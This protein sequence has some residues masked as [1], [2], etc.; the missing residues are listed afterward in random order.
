MAGLH[1]DG[2]AFGQQCGQHDGV[3]VGALDL[4][5][6]GLEVHVAL[7]ERFG[8]R[9]RNL[10]VFQGLLEVVVAALGEDV[11]VAV[12]HGHVLQ[13]GLSLDG[14]NRGRQHVGFGNRV[15]EHVVADGR[16]A[17]SGIRGAEGN[18]LGR[19]GDRVG[20]LGRVRQRRAE[21]HQDVVFED[22]FLEDVDG[23]FFLALFVF[24]HQHQLV[25]VDAARGVD[26]V[27]GK[28]ETVADRHAILSGAAGQGFRHTQLDVSRVRSR[29]DTGGDQRGQQLLGLGLHG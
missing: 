21:D 19:L 23:F 24:N 2:R 22:Q 25:A 15:A 20:G 28:L 14:G 26:F 1:H 17:V 11:V 5:E 27:S 9:D 4:G 3:G 8:R 29:D 18:R 10:L 16:D 13:A 12:K 6:L 7:G